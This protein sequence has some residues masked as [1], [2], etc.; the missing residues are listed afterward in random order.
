MGCVEGF[1]ESNEDEKDDDDDDDGVDIDGSIVFP[2][3]SR[4]FTFTLSFR[5][6]ALIKFFLQGSTK[7]KQ[8]TI[9]GESPPPPTSIWDRSTSRNN[10]QLGGQSGEAAI[11]CWLGDVFW[12][13]NN[14]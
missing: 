3:W 14:P 12:L 7:D 2:S 5:A 1:D 9:T 13:K 10:I 8:D 6:K 11:Q 4:K